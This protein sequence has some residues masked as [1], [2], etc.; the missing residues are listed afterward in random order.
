MNLP[1]ACEQCGPEGYWVRAHGGLARCG[2]ARGRALA[3]LEELRKLPPLMDVEPKISTAAATAGVS[4]LSALR[5]FPAEE[6]ARI[7]VGNELRSMCN[8]GEELFWLC[9]RMP[10][11][12]T[13][14]PGIPALRAVF[15][16]K[17]FPLDR[18]TAG[19]SEAYPDGVPAEHP[20]LGRTPL[21]ALPAVRDDE[22]LELSETV[23]RPQAAP[24]TL[25][26]S[27]VGESMERLAA[28]SSL[29]H[30]PRS[31]VSSN[32]PA[33]TEVDVSKALE[34]LHE[35]QARAELEPDQG[36]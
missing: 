6:G 12:F 3:A 32:F 36:A 26:L 4:M 9:S 35:R 27:A 33:I 15:C 31:P 24:V 17:F 7:I 1:E 14:W 28:P 20:A 16:S 34:E 13:D 30:I 21:L 18:Y 25:R 23:R 19:I 8:T 11:L 29:L 5:Y 22:V 2:C 10:R